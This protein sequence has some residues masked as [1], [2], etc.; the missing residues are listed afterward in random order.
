VIIGEDK[1]KLKNIPAFC[2]SVSSFLAAGRTPLKREWQP[3]NGPGPGRLKLIRR[4]KCPQNQFSARNVLPY[5]RCSDRC[6][7]G[8]LMSLSMD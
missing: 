6:A 1:T 3:T 5:C 4:R 2:K 7:L 8:L